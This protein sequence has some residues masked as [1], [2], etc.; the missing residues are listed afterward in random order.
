VR[1]LADAEPLLTPAAARL[2]YEAALERWP[3]DELVQ[4][5]AAG[6]LLGSGDAVQATGLYRRLLATNPGHVAARN[7]L[8]NALAARGCYAEGLAEARTALAGS[9]ASAEITDAIR[10]TV[11]ELERALA[12]GPAAGASCP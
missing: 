1:A 6:Q 7:N 2:G 10:D 8:A 5:A 3:D 11:A 4:F 9:D 12:G